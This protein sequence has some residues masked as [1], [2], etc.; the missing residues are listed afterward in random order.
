M[1]LLIKGRTENLVQ[2]F[3]QI[4]KAIREGLDYARRKDLELS[5]VES[6]WIEVKMKHTN[7][8]LVCSVYRPPSSSAE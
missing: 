2:T 8:F 3:H 7:S 1:V 6:I 4:M 5:D